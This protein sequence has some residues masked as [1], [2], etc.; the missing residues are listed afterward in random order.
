MFAALSVCEGGFGLELAE[1]LGAALGLGDGEV[2]DAI[3]DLWD[4]SLIGTEGSEPGRARYRMLALISDYSSR[5]L[6]L[7]GNRA[8]VAEAHALYFA[9]LAARVAKCPYGPQEPENVATVAREFDNIRAAFAWCV[10]AGTWELAMRLLDSVVPELVLRERIEIG[11]WASETLATLGENE[12]A[13]RALALAVSANTALVEGR[14]TDAEDLSRRSLELEAR[15]GAPITWLSR[16][17]LALVCASGSQFEEAEGFLQGLVE[18]TAVSGDPMPHAVACFDRAL[19]ASFSTDPAGGLPWANELVALGDRWGSASLRAMGLVSVGRVLSAQEPERARRALVE[20][21]TLAEESHSGLLADQAK[22]VLSEI[23]AA[24]GGHR[25]GLV[26][27][28]ELLQG[29]GRSG[30]LSQQLQ[31]VVS[32]LDPLMAVGAFDVATQLCGGLGQ[33][34]LGSVVQCER[35]L[36]AARTRLSNE[37]YRTAFGQGAH[38]SP[39][40]LMRVAAAEIERLTDQV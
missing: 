4:Q 27:L 7:D 2:A 15:L 40:E 13:V 21:V 6:D 11:R 31:T 1:A 14:L 18:I 16:N 20:A 23:H 34:A 35:A 19:V 3:A 24:R 8:K 30:D 9:T 17:V 22:R 26:A 36:E 32:T 38:L 25:A 12:H 28:G 29:F 39:T 37:A 5:Q 10:A 33:T